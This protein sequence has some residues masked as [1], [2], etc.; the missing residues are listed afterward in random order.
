M[1]NSSASGP[2]GAFEGYASV[3][4]RVDRGRDIVVRGAFAR[5]I[6]ERGARGV[7]LLWQHDPTEPIGILDEIREDSRGLYVRGRLLLGLKRAR[8]AYDLMRASALDG[9]SIGYRTVTAVREEKTGLRRLRDVDLWE[10]S[11]VTFPMQDAARVVAFKSTRT[12]V[13]APW[14]DALAGLRRIHADLAYDR[15]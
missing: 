5:S 10:V 7:K 2:A 4:D 3:F 1:K 11:L 14:A 12:E 6:T 9:L 13:T 15:L 8:E